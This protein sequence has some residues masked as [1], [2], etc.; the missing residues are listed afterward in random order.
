MLVALACVVLPSP[1]AAQIFDTATHLVPQPREMQTTAGEFRFTAATRILVASRA[2]ADRFAAGLL[3]GDIKSLR[4]RAPA[5]AAARAL[6]ASGSVI[7]LTR[8]GDSSVRARLRRAK[9]LDDRPLDDE[10]YL[11][12]SEPG[13]VIIAANT[14]QGMFYGVQ[15]LRQLV[16][17]AAEVRSPGPALRQAQ[18]AVS[19]IVSCPA[20]SIRDWP[21]MRWRGLH[22]DVSRGPIPTLDYMKAQVRTLAEY[23]LNL[24]SLYME[25]VFDYPSDPLPGPKPGAITADEIR[26]LVDYARGYHVTILP[27]QQAFGHLHHLL[28]YDLYADI[29]ETPHGHVLTPTNPATYAFIERIYKQLVPLFPGPLFHIGADET[30]ELGRGQTQALAQSE[31]LGE[32]YVEHLRKVNEIMQPYGK[33]LLFWGDIAIRYPEL[34]TSLPKTMIADA[35]G[36]GASAS[37]TRSIAPYREAGLDVIVSPGASNWSRIFPDLTTAFTNI[38]NFVRDGQQLKALGMLNTTWDD[39]GEALFAMTWPAVVFGAACAWQPGESS[40]EEFGRRFDWAFYRGTTTAFQD[41]ITQLASTHTILSGAKVGDA[42]DDAFWLDPFGQDWAAYVE[43]ARPVAKQLRLA[44]ER[45]LVLL[46]QH[47]AEATHHAETIDALLLAGRRLDSLGMKIEFIDEINQFYRQAYASQNDRR[48]VNSNLGQITGDNGRL[49]DLRDATNDVRRLYERQW[50]QESRPYWLQN[51]L[52]RYENLAAKFQAKIGEVEAA[53]AQYRRTGQLPPPEQMG[54]LV[55][56]RA[57][58]VEGR[59]EEEKDAA[60][61]RAATRLLPFA[62]CL[63]PCRNGQ[64]PT[65]PTRARSTLGLSTAAPRVRQG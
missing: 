10:G 24:L 64:R 43:N 1:S 59:R 18:G 37:F 61:R 50:L 5:I 63:L 17:R 32:V 7:Y 62:F 54:F 14:A 56:K 58:N 31:G 3:A 45:A 40:I 8:L 55:K 27:E 2:A 41:A 46:Y 4:G 30:F 15:T 19:P 51:V 22:D 52:A 25:H 21:A 47:R 65:C 36:Y 60:E 20:L 29:A 11:L 26:Q 57:E 34:L 6:P 38:R 53:A 28:K 16:H 9:L 23:K 35:W 12:L 48:L 42:S 39:D 13:R 49:A 33:R 44:A